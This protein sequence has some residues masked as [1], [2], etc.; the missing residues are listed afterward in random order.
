MFSFILSLLIV[1]KGYFFAQIS[2][3]SIGATYMT[4]LHTFSNI[5]KYKSIYSEIIYKLDT[6]KF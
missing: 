2:D 1:S 4:L 5:G 3:K 6:Y